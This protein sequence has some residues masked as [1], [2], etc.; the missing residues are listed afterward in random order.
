[1]FPWG[2]RRMAIEGSVFNSCTFHRFSI[3]REEA[4]ISAWGGKNAGSAV[5]VVEQEAHTGLPSG[6]SQV[7]IPLPTSGTPPHMS[8]KANCLAQTGHKDGRDYFPPRYPFWSYS[9]V[10]NS[11]AVHCLEEFCWVIPK[12]LFFPQPYQNLSSYHSTP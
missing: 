2:G 7:H 5:K 1:M 8:K 6:D 4:S 9:V 12:A 11:S 10:S 3:G